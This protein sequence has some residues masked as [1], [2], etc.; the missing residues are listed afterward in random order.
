MAG[1][2][3]IVFTDGACLGNPGKGGWAWAVPNGRFASGAEK[4]TTNQRM[5]IRA[6]LEAA[7]ALKGPLEIVSDSTYVVHCFRDRWWEGWLRNGWRNSAKKPVANQD[8]W[9]PLVE[10]YQADPGRL[11]FR[12]V[13]G[14]S[15]D[16]MNDLVDRL[17]VDAARAQQGRTGL[18]IPDDLGAADAPSMSPDVDERVPAGR[19]LVV[20]GL[21]PPGLG[22]YDENVIALGVK[23]KLVEILSAK[24]VLHRDLVVLTGLG[25][26]AEQLGAEAAMEADV[27][28]VAVMPFPGQEEVWPSMGSRLRYQK[29]LLKAADQV[30]LQAK[31]PE[32][33]QKAGAALSRRDAWLARH[34]DEAVVVWD[35][36]DEFVGKTMR[37]LQDH[38]GEEEVWVLD[39]GEL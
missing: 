21:R 14:H 22:G 20:T 33:K 25:L 11:A 1:N 30:L 2:R 36:R 35:G 5:E 24:K 32:N 13:K 16:P 37:S 19:K 29:L 31:K 4:M 10:L 9:E 39:P 18:G 26:G 7:T 12:W 17:A 34:A 38:V 15:N 3:T 6:A 27:P 28:Y 23:K 8:L